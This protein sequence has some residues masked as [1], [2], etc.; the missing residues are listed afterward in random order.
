MNTNWLPVVSSEA[1]PLLADREI[2][3]I[4]FKSS[5]SPYDIPLAMR[6]RIDDERQMFIV[7]FKYPTEEPVVEKSSD[8]SAS[9]EIGTLSKRL[10]RVNVDL[11]KMGERIGVKVDSHMVALAAD[12]AI[13]AIMAVLKIVPAS[14]SNQISENRLSEH[15]GVTR[16]LL[17]N[18][19]DRLIEEWAN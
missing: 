13:E 12:K 15:Y 19:R 9:F 14:A 17:L 4:R 10:Y 16:S 11:R 3:G 5:L 18:N 1:R 7:E 6:A 2:G 8:C